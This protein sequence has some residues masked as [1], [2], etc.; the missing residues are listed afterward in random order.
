MK[1]PLFKS[2]E[3]A[4]EFWADHDS[5]DYIDEMKEEKVE[6]DPKLKESIL[7]RSFFSLMDL[8]PRYMMKI[9]EIAIENKTTPLSLIRKW[10][11]QLCE[12]N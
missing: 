6:L 12:K 5:T 4:A 2:E 11:I 7:E 3:E 8:E 10:I 1:I 9:K